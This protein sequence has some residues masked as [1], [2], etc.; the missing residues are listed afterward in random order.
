SMI[1]AVNIV[2]SLFYGV[3]LGIF[4]T[5]F[6]APKI[7]AKATFWAAILGEIAVVACWYYDIMA[8]LWL[9]V[10]GCLL[11][12]GFAWIIQQVNLKTS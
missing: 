5:A 2:G 11:V 8:F 12:V 10:V 3:I 6:Y 9:N 4:L 1:E 7:G